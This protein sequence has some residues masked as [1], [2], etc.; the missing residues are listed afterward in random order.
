MTQVNVNPSGPPV[1]EDSADRSTAAGI[2]LLTVVVVLAVVVALVWFLFSGPVG[3]L[4]R[5]TNDV[6][7]NVNTP[8]QS[9]PAQTAPGGASAPVAPAAAPAAPGAAPAGR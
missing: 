2:N 6:N 9:A 8:A 1:R 4:F 3:G 7:I 5:G